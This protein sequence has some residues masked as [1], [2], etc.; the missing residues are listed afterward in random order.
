MKRKESM[1]RPGAERPRWGLA[2]SLGGMVG[3]LSGFAAWMPS[4]AYAVEPPNATK[5]VADVESPVDQSLEAMKAGCSDYLDK[6]KLSASVLRR[7]ASNALEKSLLHQELMRA[8]GLNDKLAQIVQ[9]FAKDTAGEM[10]P[11]LLSMMRQTR[12]Q[13]NTPM[14]GRPKG[15]VEMDAQCRKL[16]A[17]VESM[18]DTASRM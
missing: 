1:R 9:A 11:I 15:A 14:K 6:S 4:D 16:W 5:L 12:A 17:V 18:E 2:L 13:M 10:K 8:R 3:A 7:A